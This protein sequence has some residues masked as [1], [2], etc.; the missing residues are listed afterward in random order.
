M[1]AGVCS[2]S[3][4]AYEDIGRLSTLELSDFGRG[5]I[6]I[7]LD[8]SQVFLDLLQPVQWRREIAQTRGHERAC[9]CVGYPI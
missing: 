4:K 9:Y 3:Q 1:S 8:R 6:R 2:I 7:L 5:R